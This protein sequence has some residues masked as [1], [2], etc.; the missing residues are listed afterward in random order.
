[1]AISNRDRGG[2]GVLLKNAKLM[3]LA[4][5]TRF[6]VAAMDKLMGPFIKL[7]NSHACSWRCTAVKRA[8]RDFPLNQTCRLLVARNVAVSHLRIFEK[9]RNR[10]CLDAQQVIQRS[11]S[12]HD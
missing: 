6:D 12:L 2:S 4:I 8:L 7:R 5:S 3:T 11:R 9:C 1:M 10:L